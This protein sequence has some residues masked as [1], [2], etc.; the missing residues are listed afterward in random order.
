MK[1]QY[2]GW[3]V[4]AA[5]EGHPCIVSGACMIKHQ[6]IYAQE[7]PLLKSSIFL[8]QHCAHLAV[9]NL[10]QQYCILLFKKKHSD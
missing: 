10:Y 7:K 1:T 3:M 4:V 6:T 5:A 8:A 2:N 9:F